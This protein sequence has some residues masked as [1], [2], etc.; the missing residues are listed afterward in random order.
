MAKKKPAKKIVK[1][2]AAATPLTAAQII[3]KEKRKNEYMKAY[4]VKYREKLKAG[5][6]GANI[7]CS[8][9]KDSDKLKPGPKPSKSAKPVKKSAPKKKTK[10][11]EPATV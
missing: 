1:K 6:K 5:K 7:K 9:L 3:A 10:K 2:S 4:M 11:A 8:P